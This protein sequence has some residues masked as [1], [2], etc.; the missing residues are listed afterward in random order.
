MSINIITLHFSFVDMMIHTVRFSNVKPS[1]PF[2][3][4]P[5]MIMEYK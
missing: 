5:Y 1:L 2:H 4:Q 3:N